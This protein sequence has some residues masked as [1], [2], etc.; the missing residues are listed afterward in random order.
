M[1]GAQSETVFTYAAPALELRRGGGIDIVCHALESWT[2]RPYDRYPRKSPAGVAGRVD[3]SLAQQRLLA[4]APRPVTARDLA[5][6]LER[7]PELW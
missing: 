2:T 5:G 1:S 3:G 4:T 7:S 6:I